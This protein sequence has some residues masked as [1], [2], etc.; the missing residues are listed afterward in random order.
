MN[1]ATCLVFC[2]VALVAGCGGGDRNPTAARGEPCSPATVHYE[3]YPGHGKGLDGLPW[4]A[5]EP[6]G[7]GLVGLLSY[8]PPGWKDV[9]AAR[10]WTG[11]VAPQG[12]NLKMLWVFTAPSARSAADTELRVVGRRMD[13]PGSFHDTFAGIGYEGSDGAPSYA[14]I[15]DVP[16]PGCWR[17]T[18]TTGSVKASVDVRAVRG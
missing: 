15:I 18:L 13:G 7:P 3:S 12:Y 8:W 6:S 16:R 4:I 5:A 2:A 10:I 14:S 11:G 17:L 9:R 1:R